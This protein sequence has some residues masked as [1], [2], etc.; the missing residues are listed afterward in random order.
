MCRVVQVGLQPVPWHKSS[1][2]ASWCQ[3]TAPTW[4]SA[5]AATTRPGKARQLGLRMWPGP[6]TSPKGRGHFWK[7]TVAQ[8]ASVISAGS[9][10]TV[11][12]KHDTPLR[13]SDRPSPLQNPGGGWAGVQRRICGLNFWVLLL[14]LQLQFT[15]DLRSCSKASP[16]SKTE[17][18]RQ[19]SFSR[20]DHL[21]DIQQ[22]RTCVFG[23]LWALLS[24]TFGACVVIHICI[25]IF[26]ISFLV[27][28]PVC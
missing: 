13:G 5:T 22:Y 19:V 3:G 16:P 21:K 26:S 10:R 20:A 28:L 12:E 9:Q 6:F 4:V 15:I 24:Q 23:K 7:D 11:S 18:K 17:T 14:P 27:A 25:L 1:A 8:G 2:G